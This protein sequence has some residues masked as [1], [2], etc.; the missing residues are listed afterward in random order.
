MEDL[1]EY[2]HYLYAILDDTDLL[3]KV[4][5]KDVECVAELLNRMKSL[6]LGEETEIIQFDDLK[7]D[8][9]FVEK[10][11]TRI[12]QHPDMY[13]LYRKIYLAKERLVEE[14]L[15]SYLEGKESNF[16]AD[17]KLQNGCVRVGQTKMFAN[18]FSSYKNFADKLREKWVRD[19][20]AFFADRREFD[21]YMHMIST[22]PGAEDLYSG[23]HGLAYMP[24][25]VK[26]VE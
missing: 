19:S 7:R 20:Q 3:T 4:S 22:I 15:V 9:T 10:A 21:L 12:L 2:L 13:S 18:N 25:W 26:G 1:V 8:E 11:A 6:M 5:R 16:F 24:Q 14:N 23:A 17:T